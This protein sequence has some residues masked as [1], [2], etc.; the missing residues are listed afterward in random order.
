MVGS[1]N[2]GVVGD[3]KMSVESSTIGDKHDMDSGC[4]DR[5]G[6]GEPAVMETASHNSREGDWWVVGSKNK[7]V[8]GDGKIAVESITAEDKV[9]S[10]S[11]FITRLPEDGWEENNSGD[12]LVESVMGIWV[13]GTDWEELGLLCV[14]SL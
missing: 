10:G 2:D 6:S 1:K 3:G 11:E 4:V 5:S 9:D 13:S 8:A 12:E 14:G 7:G